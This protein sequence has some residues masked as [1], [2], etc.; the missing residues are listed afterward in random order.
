MSLTDHGTTM[1]RMHADERTE[2]LNVI[3]KGTLA[4]RKQTRAHILLRADEGATDEAIAAS[5]H[6]HRTAM[7]PVVLSLVPPSQRPI[8]AAL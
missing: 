8:H 7:R 5:L 6:I 4:A 3:K 2:L 1:S